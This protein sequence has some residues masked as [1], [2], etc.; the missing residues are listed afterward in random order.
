M[1]QGGSGYP[2][3][4]PSI[5]SY[6]SGVETCSILINQEEISD[7]EVEEVLQKV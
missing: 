2:Y 3:F 5:F 7:P 1:V 6:L 4:A